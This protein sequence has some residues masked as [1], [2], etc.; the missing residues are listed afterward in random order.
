MTHNIRCETAKN[1]PCTCRCKGKLHQIHT[2]DLNGGT[3]MT[4]KMGGGVAQYIRKLKGKQFKCTN[5]ARREI[6]LFVGY[7]GS[8]GIRDKNR[9]EWLVYVKC[10]FLISQK[11]AKD[12]DFI[13]ETNNNY[14]GYCRKYEK[15][16][17]SLQGC[18]IDVTTMT[19]V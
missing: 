11:T 2:K 5:G 10:R 19:T 12:Y 3:F 16:L 18:L 6:A 15:N 1:P 13:T 7:P 4:P 9:K 14:Q 8:G 17:V